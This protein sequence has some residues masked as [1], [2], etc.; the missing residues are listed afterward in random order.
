MIDLITKNYYI[1][2]H[3]I[4]IKYSFCDL[5]PSRLHALKDVEPGI[6]LSEAHGQ[7]PAMGVQTQG[8]C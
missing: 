3:K 6:D 7:Q 5:N 4:L 1:I 8:R 2:N